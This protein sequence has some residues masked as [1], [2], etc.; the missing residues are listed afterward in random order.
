MSGVIFV[1]TKGYAIDTTRLCSLVDISPRGIGIDCPEPLAIDTFVQVHS[2]DNAP[3]R[4][5]RVRHC[6]ELGDVYR[7]GL[8]IVA[9]P[10]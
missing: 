10:Q 2:D 6:H 1:T 8:Q 5:A 9:G 4:H 7:V 3:R